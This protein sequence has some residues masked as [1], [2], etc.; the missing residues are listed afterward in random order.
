MVIA[1]AV[2]MAL[3]VSGI[4]LTE[5][6]ASLLR[7]NAHERL[8]TAALSRLSEV[9]ARLEGEINATLHIA[10]GLV[11]YVATRPDLTQDEFASFAA[12]TMVIGRNIRN[13]ALA[14]QNVIAFIYP[15]AGN[16]SAL[17]LDYSKNEEQWPGVRQAMEEKTTVVAGPVDLVQGGRAL[18]ARTPIYIAPPTSDPQAERDYWGIASVVI[19]ADG[20][21]ADAGIRPLSLGYDFAVRGAHGL[22]ADGAMMLGNSKLFNGDAV[23]LP[24]TLPA[25]SWLIAARP[26]QGWKI[27]QASILLARGIG[28]SVSV[29]LAALATLLVLAHQKARSMALHDALTGLPNRRLLEDRLDQLTA[30]AE[31]TDI[32]FQ[33][34]FVDL[35]GFKPVNDAFGHAV[36]DALLQEVGRRLLDETR[37]SDT[38][39]R[40]GGDEFVVVVPGAT[41]AMATHA[42]CERFRNRVKEPLMVGEKAIRIEASVGWASYPEDADTVQ[43]ILELADKRM[44][45]AKISG[46]A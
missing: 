5:Y 9:R 39:A 7:E 28:F 34:F 45:H 46:A 36:G 2:G 22:G 20:L 16:D 17:G 33:V 25:G 29:A 19:D 32:S 6:V 3:F 14:P 38:V 43:A 40:I 21:F 18:I 44:Y 13:V 24:V 42:I 11:S 15:L 27:D 1:L 37:K 41:G 4:T 10:Q 8:Q 23:T 30:L 31:R 35:N 26:S 12:E